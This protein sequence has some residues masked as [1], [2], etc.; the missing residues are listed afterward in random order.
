MSQT[1]KK[2]G[3]ELN[4]SYDVITSGY[5]VKIIFESSFFFWT[6]EGWFIRVLLAYKKVELFHCRCYQFM[7]VDA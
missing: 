3:G 1:L 5:Q 7:I 4:G 6:F 2:N